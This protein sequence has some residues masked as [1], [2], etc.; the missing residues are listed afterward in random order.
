MLGSYEQYRTRGDGY[1]LKSIIKTI[2][3]MLVIIFLVYVVVTG[4][5][6]DTYSIHS[7]SMNPALSDSEMVLTA[8][9]VYGAYN[10]LLGV[11]F[12]GF[13]KPARGDIVM[14]KPPYLPGRS[15]LSKLISPLLRFFSFQQAG[16]VR[17]PAGNLVNERVIKRI[18]GVPGDAIKIERFI[19][20][21]RPKGA[22]E[23]KTERELTG[24]SYE[25]FDEFSEYIFPEGWNQSLPFSGYMQEIILGEDEY[26]VIGD[27]R[28]LF[29]DSRFSGPV[30]FDAIIS[31]VVFRYWPFEKFGG[32]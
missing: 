8:P 17:D 22:R 23:F 29:S 14:V 2:I 21:I 27:N 24:N 10:S 4:F 18:V 26:F 28:L 11:R 13:A 7:T 30:R 5:F 32:F 16:L 12:P 6:V 15:F 9:I 20:Y 3:K 1:S 31:K 25:I 19:V